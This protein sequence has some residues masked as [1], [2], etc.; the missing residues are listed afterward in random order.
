MPPIS[1]GKIFHRHHMHTGEE[2]P[3]NESDAQMALFEASRL[4][5]P[6]GDCPTMDEFAHFFFRFCL[7]DMPRGTFGD[8]SEGVSAAQEFLYLWFDK[9]C[10][11][12]QSLVDDAD[13]AAVIAGESTDLL[14]ALW[15]PC[16]TMMEATKTLKA[17][18]LSPDLDDTIRDCMLSLG[19]WDALLDEDNPPIV[20]EQDSLPYRREMRI[21]QLESDTSENL[22]IRRH[23]LTTEFFCFVLA[24][25]VCSYATKILFERNT[26]Y[27]AVS[28]F[29]GLLS[30]LADYRTVISIVDVDALSDIVEIEKAMWTPSGADVVYGVTT[31]RSDGAHFQYVVTPHEFEV[32]SEELL[33]EGTILREAA[34]AVSTLSAGHRLRTGGVFAPDKVPPGFNNAGTH[35]WRVFVCFDHV[36]AL[37]STLALDGIAG[38]RI[39]FCG[40]GTGEGA[41]ALMEKDGRT[42]LGFDSFP[43]AF[44]ALN[45]HPEYEGMKIIFERE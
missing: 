31:N 36:K 26:P 10:T 17:K 24:S 41:W 16:K 37:C 3:L 12:G 29:T 5:G 9:V 35:W 11:A 25:C 4:F 8:L 18:D 14:D 23:G 27:T 39:L 38:P 32:V 1:V 7:G 30:P 43:L 40:L 45:Q 44:C 21:V 13:I 20:F 15:L 19:G 22:R 34:V 6:D 2:T 28:F 33:G 42:T